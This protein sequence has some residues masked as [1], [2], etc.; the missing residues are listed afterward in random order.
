MTEIKRRRLECGLS[1]KRLAEKVGVS[2][3]TVKNW[4]D[5]RFRPSEKHLSALSEAL[6]CDVA[7]ILGP[8]KNRFRRERSTEELEAEA[9]NREKAAPYIL[10]RNAL[11]LTQKDLAEKDGVHYTTISCMELGRN[12]PCWETRQKIRRALG[13]P[14]GRFYSEE[15]RNEIFFELENQGVIRYVIR[16]NYHQL[17]AVN[18]DLEDLHQELVICAL[19][20]IDRYQP[21]EQATL[22]T[23]VE[24]NMDFFIK[25]WIVKVGMHGLSGKVHYPLPDVHVIS[26][27]VLMENGFDAVE[28][29]EDFTYTGEHHI[30]RP[31]TQ[32]AD[33]SACV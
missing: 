9:V 29:M 5:G 7:E 27:D 20:A 19:R 6:M 17:R 14:E 15:E 3:F 30:K 10:R 31:H 16:K 33:Q 11:G 22:K 25:R 18:A 26:L 24:R 28:S 23:F 12:F 4:E 2:A 32:P 1:Q 21:G 13:M 8:P